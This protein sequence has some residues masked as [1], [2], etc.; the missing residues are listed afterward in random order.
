[1]VRWLAAI[2]RGFGYIT[3]GPSSRL[4]ALLELDP[5]DDGSRDVR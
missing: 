5:A 2:D 4:R 3:L 1:M